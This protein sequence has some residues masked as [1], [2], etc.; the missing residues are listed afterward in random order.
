MILK[1]LWRRRSDHEDTPAPKRGRRRI[2]LVGAAFVIFAAGMAGSF[3]AGVQ[4]Y[5]NQTV[6]RLVTWTEVHSSLAYWRGFFSGESLPT[7]NVDMSFRNLQRIEAKREEALRRGIL[8]ASAADFVPADLRFEGRTIPVDMRL[9][10]DWVDHLEGDKWSFRIEVKGDNQVLGFR[11]FSI[12]DPSTRENLFEWAYLEHL[13]SEGILAPRYEF[14]NVV[15]NGDKLGIYAVEEH[16]SKELLESQGRKEGVILRF[17]EDLYWEQRVRNGGPLGNVFDTDYTVSIIDAFRDG[18]IDKSAT[19]A[20]QRDAAIGLLRGYIEGRLSAS[21]VFDAELMGRFLA[22]TELWGSWHVLQWINLR[23]YYNPVTAKLEPIG[24]DSQHPLSILHRLISIGHLGMT[25]DPAI[26]EVYVRELVRMKSPAYLADIKERISSEYERLKKAL[27]RE[28]GFLPTPWE[29]IQ[30][31]QEVIRESLNPVITVLALRGRPMTGVDS[32]ARG[33]IDLELRNSLTLPVE[34]LGFTV[35]GGQLIPASETLKE[36]DEDARFVTR[37]SSVILLGTRGTREAVSTELASFRLPEGVLESLQ[38]DIPPEEM[39][40]EVVTRILGLTQER[41]SGVISYPQSLD[42]GLLPVTLSVEESLAAHPFLQPGDSVDTLVALPG[43]WDVSG[44]LILPQGVGLEIGPGTILLFEPGAILYASG[45]LDLHGTPEAPVVLGPQVTSWGGIVVLRAGATST[46]ANVQV[47]GTKAIARN[48]WALTGGI[49]FFESPVVLLECRITGSLGED[50]LNIIRTEFEIRSC[51]FGDTAADAFDA[52]F[53]TGR[54]FGSSFYDIAGDAID[55]SGSVVEV[56]NVTIRRIG[57]KGI[58]VGEASNVTVQNIDAEEVGIAIA[59]KD[60][61]QVTGEG[62][63]IRGARNAGLAAYTKKSE[64]GP[65]Y[66]TLNSVKF[67]DTSTETLIGLN[68]W[69]VVNSSLIDG[70]D[71]DVQTLYDIGILGN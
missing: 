59:S 17:N 2:V 31:R 9:K 69:I 22:I 36:P 24:F 1:S 12:Q 43:E 45:P 20:V 70:T 39:E 51:E 48:G 35:N 16:F 19:L 29:T 44:D 7:L 50:A 3:V 68:S 53:S 5:R 55:F 37:G 67:I 30:R 47:H 61:S 46:L 8:L 27:F 64:Y 15:F 38:A 28:F 56:T 13:R 40:I 63:V 57:D 58:S 65:G 6:Q 26:S 23:F 49:T 66:M 14:L 62:I 41:S 10:G 11:R 60:L 54:I 21:E 71:L 18:R 32:Q 33:V 4:L 52:D 42:S 34:V 25:D